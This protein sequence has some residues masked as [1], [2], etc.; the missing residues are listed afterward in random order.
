MITLLPP[1][2]AVG[3]T[4]M[5]AVA[6]VGLV[7]TRSATVTPAPITN[8]EL[9]CTQLVSEPVMVTL[10]PPD[11]CGALETHDGRS[12]VTHALTSE[13][14]AGA[15]TRKPVISCSVGSLM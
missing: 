5:V 12:A 2:G 14:V 8:S 10:V 13:G 4:L 3:D 11:P 9:P 1:T 7:I 6:E 15:S